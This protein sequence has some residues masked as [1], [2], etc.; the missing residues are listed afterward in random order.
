MAVAA[1]YEIRGMT[2]DQFDDTL[3]PGVIAH[4]AGPMEGG[5]WAVD[6]YESQEVAERLGQQI[7]PSLQ[8]MGVPAPQVQVRQVHNVLTRV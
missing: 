7:S 4:A 8:A 6:V 5:W 2:Q 3:A 1:L